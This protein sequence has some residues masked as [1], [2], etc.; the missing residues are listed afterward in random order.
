MDFAAEIVQLFDLIIAKLKNDRLFTQQLIM[1]IEESRLKTFLNELV[2]HKQ[3]QEELFA[4]LKEECYKR[5]GKPSQEVKESLRA[6]VECCCLNPA[7]EETNPNHLLKDCIRHLLLVLK[8]N[9]AFYTGLKAFFCDKKT[10]QVVNKLIEE[11]LTYLSQLYD[12][13]EEQI[14]LTQKN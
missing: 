2:S 10:K 14:S 12:F 4:L 1:Q 5:R 7:Q 9:V 13:W 11:E 3:K 8:D 6:L